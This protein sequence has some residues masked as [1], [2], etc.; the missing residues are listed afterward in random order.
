MT[1]IYR[2]K[3]SV[4]AVCGGKEQLLSNIVEKSISY[5]QL[6]VVSCKAKHQELKINTINSLL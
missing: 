6:A 4:S 1:L 3:T 2:L 5:Y